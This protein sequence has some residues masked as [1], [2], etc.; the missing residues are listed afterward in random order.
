MAK[1]TY[2]DE[3]AFREN[4]EKG[5]DTSLSI[6]RKQYI[7]DEVKNIDE[8]KLTVDFVIS[9]A[10]VDRMGDTIDVSGWDL[11]AYKKNPVVLF[12]HDNREPP[13]GRAIRIGKK[14]GKLTSRAEFTPRDMN[15]FGHSIFQMYAGG[16][17]KATSVGFRPLKFE[18]SED[19]K[20]SGGIDFLKQELLEFSAVPV[21]ANPEALLEARSAGVDTKP[22]KQWAERILDEWDEHGD[23][24]VPKRAVIAL[25]KHAGK[26]GASTQV[27]V[28]I[29][30]ELLAKNLESVKNSRAETEEMDDQEDTNND[31]VEADADIDVSKAP[32]M[33][34][35]SNGHQHRYDDAESGMTLEADGH[36]H[37][38]TIMTSPEGQRVTIGTTNGHSHTAAPANID[39]G[40]LAGPHADADIEVSKDDKPIPDEV[41]DSESKDGEEDGVIDDELPNND[42]GKSVSDTTIKIVVEGSVKEVL[43]SMMDVADKALDGDFDEELKSLVGTRGG[44]RLLSNVTSTLRELAR[45]VDKMVDEDD[46]NSEVIENDA[47]PVIKKSADGQ[48]FLF[49]MEGD[50]SPDEEK[51]VDIGNDITLEDVKEALTEVL[52]QLVAEAATEQMKSFTGKV[53]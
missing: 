6:L 12:A 5:G 40:P 45:S 20:R 46:K 53:D 44:K 19:E 4:F 49:Y 41:V 29:Q 30:D 33:S 35:I 14:D 18:M 9:T 42:E 16:F 36:T 21:P 32:R 25:Q 48:D 22:F 26:S 47:E 15:P 52:P 1:A 7:C 31:F 34:G 24:M 8:E 10:S 37:P 50:N 39:E 23:L 38:I 2:V 13:I 28:D 43:G 3:K 51:D 11:R 27:S 17:M